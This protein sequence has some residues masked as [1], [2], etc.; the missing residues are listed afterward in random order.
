M[1]LCASGTL[2]LSICRWLVGPSS[3][4]KAPRLLFI[5]ICQIQPN[6]KYWDS[7]SIYSSSLFVPDFLCFTARRKVK[8]KQ[9]VP[10][11]TPAGW[12]NSHPLHLQLVPTSYVSFWPHYEICC[13]WSGLLLPFGHFNFLFHSAQIDQP[14]TGQLY[15]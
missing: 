7:N 13:S 2:L 15:I 3:L 9:P 5:L 8:P 14:M 11:Y 12:L 1:S 6:S 10:I 4:D